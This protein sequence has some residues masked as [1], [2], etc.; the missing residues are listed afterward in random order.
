M[1][2]QT[3]G[4]DSREQKK[5]MN[6]TKFLKLLASIII[7][8]SAGIIGSFFTAG[9]IETW[10]LTLNRPFFTPP[11][12]VF[13]PVWITLYTL[14]GISLYIIWEKGIKDENKKAL[15]IFF[16]QLVLNGFWSIAF[17]GFES[18]LFGLIIILPMAVLI[19]V[20]ILEFYKLN[21]TSA[22]LLIPYLAWVSIA[23]ALNA[24][25]WILN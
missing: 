20:N 21:K 16:A 5:T 18:P 6:P 4:L 2:K 9:S 22:C 10:Y 17:F 7:C 24:G 25:I 12:W 14:M 11:N 15:T 8:Q 23:T 19:A 3:R 1:K 13:A